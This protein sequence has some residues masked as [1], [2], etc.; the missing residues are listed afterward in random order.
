MTLF[1]QIYVCSLFHSNFVIISLWCLGVRMTGLRRKAKSTSNYFKQPI[2]HTIWFGICESNSHSNSFASE[3]KVKFRCYIQKL[4]VTASNWIFI[5]FSALCMCFWLKETTTVLFTC[6]TSIFCLSTFS[7]TKKGF[8]FAQTT[9]NGQCNPIQS[10]CNASV[11]R[12]FEHT[13]FWPFFHIFYFSSTLK[14]ED[15]ESSVPFSAQLANASVRLK[16]C[17]YYIP[18]TRWDRATILDK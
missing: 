2:V 3:I 17:I 16:H 10:A 14:V 11:R 12:K 4:I 9:H 5:I 8:H 15:S 18:H 7:F 13:T 1:R 6:F